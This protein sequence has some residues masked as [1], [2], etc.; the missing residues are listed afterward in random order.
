[1]VGKMQGRGGEREDG[2]GNAPLAIPDDPPLGSSTVTSASTTLPPGPLTAA[3]DGEVWQMIW[4][5]WARQSAVGEGTGEIDRTGP[6]RGSCDKGARSRQ[7]SPRSQFW[8]G[9][10]SGALSLSGVFVT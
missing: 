7:R 2:D 3:I 10:Q 8:C 5:W 9:P 6:W 4:L 1:M